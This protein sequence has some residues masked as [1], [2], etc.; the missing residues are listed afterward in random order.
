M[1]APRVPLQHIAPSRRLDAALRLA[2]GPSAGTLSATL[3]YLCEQLAALCASPVASV[4]VLEER[5]DLVLR[6]NYGFPDAVLGEVRL[7]VGQGITGTALETMRPMTVDDAALVEQFEYF[8]QLAEERYPA[9]LALPLIAGPRPRGVLVLQREAGPFSETD[10]L[11]ATAASRAVT[12]VL[13]GQHPQGANLL[14]HGTGNARGRVLGVAQ[15]LSR[16][17]PRRQRA[18]EVSSEDPHSD[19]LNAFTAE[20]GELR[21]L[22]DRA[23]SSATGRVRELEESATVIEDAR[24]QERAIEHLSARLPPSLALERIAAEFARALASHGPAARRAVDVEAFLG[25]VAHRYAALEPARIRRG[26]IVAAVHLS[27]ISALRAWASGAVGALVAGSAEESTG[28]PVLTA[29]GMP[30]ASGLRQLF[31]TVGN[32]TRVALDSDSGEVYVNPTAAQAAAW[33]R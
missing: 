9:F 22:A 20:R 26:E 23:R 2:A 32:G 10:V 5:D 28:V 3:N 29:L 12:A 7:K 30:V 16:A 8:P 21:T 13:E 31:D 19:L 11:L 18:A 33:R 4:Y 15:V 27:G 14:L 25:A 24:L 6:G 1:A 17:M